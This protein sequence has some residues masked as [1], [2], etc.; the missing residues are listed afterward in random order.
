M[1]PL[2]AGWLLAGDLKSFSLLS[3]PYENPELEAL[4]L[5][6]TELTAQSALDARLKLS[7]RPHP[8]WRFEAH[9]AASLVIG[10]ASSL[11]NSGVAS[12]AE[13][14]LPLSWS[15]DGAGGTELRGRLDRL[16]LRG[17]LGPAVLTVGRQPVGLGAGLFFTPLDLVSPFGPA[18]IDTEYKP[19]VDA[20]RV[21]LYAGERFEQT[22]V[23]AVMGESAFGG[24]GL[25]ELVLLSQSRLT[26]GT[27]DLALVLGEVRAD[28]V[29]G[30]SV[31]GSVG[32]IGLHGDGSLTLPDGEEDPFVRAVAGLSLMPEPKSTVMGEV[33]LQTLGSADPA[34]Y[35]ALYTSPRWLRG[36]LWAVGRA[37]A[38]VSYGRELSPLVS[39]SLAVIGN[40]EDPSA[41]VAPGLRVSISD[42]AELSAGAYVG[43]G[44]RPE[45]L[46]LQSE[47][48]ALP[49]T[50]FLR[51]GAWW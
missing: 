41:M 25:H 20:A 24:R 32:A 21:D 19:G 3:L 1:S 7:W 9:Q 23:A 12:T 13:E 47:L 43:L 45:G 16:V 31:S 37:Y 38:A 42:E 44:A 28:E 11:G 8:S 51:L 35:F 2:L 15:V 4:G 6:D 17:E 5:W 18:A 36:E 26:V 50:G 27:T 33:Y 46:D 39:G 34:D 10:E 30:L 29:V 14:W 40:L 22:F 49:T 48:G